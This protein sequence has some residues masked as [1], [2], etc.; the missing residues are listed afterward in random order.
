[1]T[2]RTESK[3]HYSSS[4][5]V[6]ESEAHHVDNVENENDEVEYALL[7]K[8]FNVWSTIGFAFS[9]TA[10]PLGIGSYL[11]F[12]MGVGGSPFFTYGYIFVVI[13]QLGVCLSLAEISSAFPHVSGTVRHTSPFAITPTNTNRYKGQIFWAKALAPPKISRG[14]SYWTGAFTIMSWTFGT[15]GSFILTGKF[16]TA[17][18]AL[19]SSE[20]QIMPYQVFLIAILSGGMC[21]TLNVWLFGLVPKIA[22]FMVVFI[23]VGIIFIMVSLLV[24]AT[25]KASAAAVFTEVVNETGWSSN[26]LVFCLNV[27]PGSLSVSAFDAAAHMAEEMN[28]PEKQVPQVMIYTALLSAM[29]GLIMIVVYEFCNTSPEALLHPIG[30]QPIFQLLLDALRSTPLLI[31]AALVFC[32]TVLLGCIFFVTTLSRIV[33]SFANHGGLPFGGFL[34]RVHQKSQIPVNAVYAVTAISCIISLLEFT[35]S[36][37]LSAC[38]GACG[39][40][41]TVSYS[42]PIWCLVFN[43]PGSQRLGKTGPFSMKR[44]GYIL[45]LVAVVWQIF[46]VIFL[47]FP[48]YYPVTVSNMNW[49]AVVLGVGVLVFACN[50]FL[51]S[52]LYFKAPKPLF[53]GIQNRP[54]E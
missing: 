35:P 39:I 25:P 21:L 16:L 13:M 38:F 22:R 14:L 3:K 46:Q 1:M 15:A 23:N 24:R 36:L 19:L 12:A 45:N 10:T 51:Y 18:G 40:A 9:L 7:R 29:S 47:S 37:I 6:R 27:L 8:R 52:R 43:G 41:G 42:I 54:H 28:H 30:G 20:Y 31:V 50:W 26:I 33:W 17:F 34:G 4:N 49:A 2:N 44:F 5:D 11:V 32:I 48:Q 53:V